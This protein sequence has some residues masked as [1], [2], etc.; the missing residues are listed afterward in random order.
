MGVMSPF[1]TR[2]DYSHFENPY[3]GLAVMIFAQAKDDLNILDGN[4][5]I[6]QNGYCI[7]KWEIINFLR[8]K[9]ARFLAGSLGIEQQLYET[10]EDVWLK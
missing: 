3:T 8:S 2:I 6:Y 4:E 5:T 9:W 7:N 1:N 10:V